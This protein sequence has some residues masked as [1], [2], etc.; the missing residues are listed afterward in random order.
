[1]DASTTIQIEMT[2]P[3]NNFY[4]DRTYSFGDVTICFILMGIFAIMISNFI[5]SFLNKDV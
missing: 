2:D 5:H 3:N 4:I 1:M